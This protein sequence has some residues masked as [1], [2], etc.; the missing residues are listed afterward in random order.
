MKKKGLVPRPKRP[1]AIYELVIR[2]EVLGRFKFYLTVGLHGGRLIELWLDCAK[3]GATLRELLH[4]WSALFSVALQ[5]GVPL[6]RLVKLYKKWKFEPCGRVEGFPGIE[7]CV[8]MLE[9]VATILEREYGTPPSF[10]GG[11]ALVAKKT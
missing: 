1:S 9:L 4:A 6:A 8:S 11:G 10:I 2:S 7:S 5:E 3:E